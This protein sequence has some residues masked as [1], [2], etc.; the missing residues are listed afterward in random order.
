MPR[1]THGMT[2]T[3]TYRCWLAMKGR[4]RNA[5]VRC[6]RNYG[7]RGLG[8]DPAWAHFERFLEDMGPRPPGKL[9]IERRDNSRGYS[10]AN[11]YWA[12]L[13]EQNNN[14]RTN[15]RLTFR[16]RTQTLAQW[17]RELG[18][19][20]ITLRTRLRRGWP[21]DLALRPGSYQG[22]RN[23]GLTPPS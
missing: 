5:R 16:G 2:G 21:L 9:S 20:R 11:C 1:K 23:F 6:Y 4:C 15:H 12:M 17:G 18:L 13:Q 7:G 8:Y 3:P 22:Q 19:S 10:K 14:K